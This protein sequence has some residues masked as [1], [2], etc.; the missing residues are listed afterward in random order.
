MNIDN[1][2]RFTDVENKLTV[3]SGDREGDEGRTRYRIKRKSI[4]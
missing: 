4:L 2:N 1:R 3:T